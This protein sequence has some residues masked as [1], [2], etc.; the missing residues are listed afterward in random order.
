MKGFD[1][2]VIDKR[3][4]V[5]LGT[6]KGNAGSLR[7]STYSPMAN[8]SMPGK[9]AKAFLE[10]D[11]VY[12]FDFAELLARNT[13]FLKV[14]SDWFV[15]TTYDLAKKE[16]FHD[17]AHM[18]MTGAKTVCFDPPAFESASEGAKKNKN[19]DVEVLNSKQILKLEPS[20]KRE[21]PEVPGCVLAKRDGHGDAQKFTSAL[22]R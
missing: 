2:T 22:A 11:P 6:S 15:D 14:N 3:A 5:G 10:G 20:L 16:G 9:L 12:S 7:T 4:D 1:V 17:E 18:E 8:S 21:H 19:P 13:Q